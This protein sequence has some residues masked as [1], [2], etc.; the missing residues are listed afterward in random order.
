MQAASG[1]DVLNDMFGATRD[2]VAANKT[3]SRGSG[4]LFAGLGDDLHGALG[5]REI[6]EA[7]RAAD[8]AT[9][10]ESSAAVR[11]ED[12]LNRAFGEGS[13]VPAA[14]ATTTTGSADRA[15]AL[16]EAAGAGF[17]TELDAVFGDVGGVGET[18]PPKT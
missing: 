6:H 16:S 10:N 2:S 3:A 1:H 17:D 12:E 11:F 18:V 13:T 5:G 9:P 14:G 4:S 15:A 8:D 7:T